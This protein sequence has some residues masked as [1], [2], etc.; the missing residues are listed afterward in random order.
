MTNYPWFRFYSEVLIDKKI[1]RVCRACQVPKATVIGVWTM[2][3]ALAND[4]PE[5]GHLMIAAD[6]WLSAEEIREETGLDAPAFEAIMEQFEV[7][8]MIERSEGVTVCNWD[9]RQFKSDH[10][11]DRV[12][13]H[14]AKQRERDSN[15]TETDQQRES[16]L[17]DTDT[18]PDPNTDTET[19]TEQAEEGQ[20]P[21]SKGTPAMEHYWDRWK[22][23]FK[24][25]DLDA[26]LRIEQELGSARIIEAIDWGYFHSPSI[27]GINAIITAARKWQGEIPEPPEPPPKEQVYVFPGINR[28]PEYLGG[29]P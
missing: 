20:K 8:R 10:S 26:L 13:R 14:R 21:K 1:K 4:S 29:D 19:E 3:L 12:K 5:R 22:T 24:G 27:S 7:L 9:K 23:R 11:N 25:D 18:D 6:M 17:L 2:L 15:V 28:D 16:N